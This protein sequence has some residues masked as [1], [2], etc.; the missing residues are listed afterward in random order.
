MDFVKETH[1]LLNHYLGEPHRGSKRLSPEHQE[2]KDKVCKLVLC[3][4]KVGRVQAAQ[5][6]Q[7]TL[8]EEHRKTT[9][10]IGEQHK[11]M[12]QEMNDDK[13]VRPADE[14]EREG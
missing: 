3:A 11:L 14:P 1:D 7:E 10:A 5:E 12:R 4:M 13:Y 6:L 2:L 8:S 9:D